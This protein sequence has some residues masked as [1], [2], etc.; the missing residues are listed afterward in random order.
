M[1]VLA[2]DD[3][4]VLAKDDMGFPFDQADWQANGPMLAVAD[5]LARFAGL[6]CKTRG[7]A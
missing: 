3:M 5:P 4:G 2:K 7:T 6:Q 1:G